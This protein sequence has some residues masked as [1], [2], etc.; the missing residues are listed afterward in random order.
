MRTF[1]ITTLLIYCALPLK[2]QQL[3]FF[4]PDHLKQLPSSETY[5]I[6]Q[7]SRGYIWFST[8]AGLCRYNGKT[9]KIF[10][11]KEGLPEAATYNIWEDKKGLIWVTTSR[12]RVL[13]YE[14]GKDT[15]R[16]A[17]F[18][19]SIEKVL[20]PN[21]Q[22]IYLA[23]LI[24]DAELWL[25]TQY[26]TLRV[27]L[28]SGTMKQVV[29]ADTVSYNFEEKKRAMIPLKL[30]DERIRKLSMRDTVFFRVTKGEQNIRIPIAYKKEVVANHQMPAA[31]NKKGESFIAIDHFL[32]KINADLSWE[33]LNMGS[34][35]LN[36]YADKDGGLWVAMFKNGVM[37]FP[38]EVKEG[39]GLKSLLGLSV[40][41]I[42]EDNEKGIW[43]STL[44]DGIFYSRNKFVLNYANIPGL[45]KKSELLKKVED[46]VFISSEKSEL[47]SVRKTIVLK[48]NLENTSGR[49]LTDILFHQNSWFIA[50]K[51]RVYITDPNFRMINNVHGANQLS[52]TADKRIFGIDYGSLLE[53]KNGK[54]KFLLIPLR[55]PGTGLLAQSHAGMLVGCR[56]GVYR[57]DTSDFS[58]HRID[59]VEGSVTKMIE[60]AD[61]L[62][63][64]VTKQKGIYAIKDKTIL[65]ISD[66]LGLPTNRFSD[67]TEDSYGTL[68]AASNIGLVRIQRPFSKKNTRIYNSMHGLPSNEV[69]RVAAD[70]DRVYISTNEGL[71]SFPLR[72]ELANSTRPYIHLNSVLV[73][74]QAAGIKTDAA[75]PFDKNNVRI[76]F[77]L[78]TFKK[79]GAPPRLFYMVQGADESMRY[80]EGNEV[81]LNNLSPGSYKVIA[82]AINND[83]M[84]S[85]VPAVWSFEIK[86][87]FWQTLFFITGMALLFV[88]LT[89]FL[90]KL[91]IMRIRKKE[92][93]KTR[94]N[95]LLAEYQMSALRAQMNP[96]FIFNCI[97][98]IQRYIITN[99]AEEAYNY[100]AKFSK[101][102][103]M[104]LNHAEENVISLAQELEIVEIY[105][106]L[107]QLRFEN[108]FNY[109]IEIDENID[110]NQVMV[111]AMIM[112]PYI[113]NAI[114]HG[115][116]N[117]EKGKTGSISIRMKLDKDLL[118]IVIEDNGVGLEQAHLLRKKDHRSKGTQI[119]LRRTEILN[120]IS[121]GGGKVKIEEIAEPTHKGTRVTLE[122]P[123]TNNDDE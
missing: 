104:V 27:E 61:K 46:Q 84:P 109:K 70:N 28:P 32:V 67:I 107:E 58:Q 44:E 122:I 73:N 57:I 48:Q 45:D 108:K 10:N 69:F 100:L 112:Q 83:G 91:I 96:H 30:W 11:E 68:W 71:S 21:L 50:D 82:Y 19:K 54:A 17:P 34:R 87:P 60:T 4:K 6:I 2:A 85:P 65:R 38:N 123:Q 97:N 42:C 9:T 117:L 77:D 18:S 53:I 25:C 63:L 94:V 1:A 95:K 13:F 37:Y 7:D 98:S 93:E 102:I 90:V 115:L 88:L 101:L 16:E 56:E 52:V 121:G 72:Y 24:N 41:G 113:E 8:E 79:A 33:I 75:F 47:F 62:I 103:R 43:C 78:L 118:R 120:I 23:R 12:N 40:T 119:N 64:I 89:Y 15:L 76:V 81:L 59:G 29:P 99:K 31:T 116:M 5:N 74:D 92:E 55:S 51:D 114:W 49:G 14:F 86:K 110:E 22:Q 35:V 80:A 20:K 111:P 105:I 3:G 36:L 106:E 39:K 66:S 26:I